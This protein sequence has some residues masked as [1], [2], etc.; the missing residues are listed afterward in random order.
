MRCMGRDRPP[1]AWTIGYRGI[2][3]IVRNGNRIVAFLLL[4]TAALNMPQAMVLCVGH[5]GHVAIEPAGHDHCA[6]GSHV[7]GYR[8]EG[9]EHSHVGC[10]HCRPCVDI[11]IPIGAGDNRIASQRSKL[12]PT[13]LAGLPPMIQTPDV[14]E[15][16]DT[17]AFS[18]FWLL[19]FSGSP[20][21]CVILQV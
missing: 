8:P 2:L 5:D 15:T 14:L 7:P 18:S 17:V 4:S 19:S 1:M 20:P 12:T 9:S 13:Y 11:P 21:R 16:P 10:P 6:D 3:R